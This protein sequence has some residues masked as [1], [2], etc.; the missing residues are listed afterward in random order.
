MNGNVAM[1]YRNPAIVRKAGMSVLQKELGTVGTV[2]FLRQ[3]EIGNGNYTEEREPLLAGITIDEIV[4]SV[5]E[6]DKQHG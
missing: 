2:Y 3:F 5:R 1:D 4:K 6:L